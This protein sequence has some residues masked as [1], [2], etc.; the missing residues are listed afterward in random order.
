MLTMIVPMYMSEVS[1][2]AVRGTLVVLQQLSITI[3]ILISYWIEFGTQYIGGT[4]CD[5][6]IPYS[7][8]TTADPT[9]DPYN[10]LGPRGCTGQSEASWRIPLALQ[11]IPA[12]IL[13]IGML[14][15]PESP[16]Y[17]CMR[18]Q[19]EPALRALSTIRQTTPDSPA[20]CRE[21]LT[22]KAEVL[23]EASL[24]RDLYPNKTGVSLYLAQY[25]SLVS[26]SPARKRLAVGCCTM[27]FQQFMGCNAIIYYAPTIFAQLGLS[28]RATSLLATGVYGI[29]NTL[30][31]LPAL[32]LIDRVG[33][34]PLLMA[35]AAGTCVSLVVVA[36]MVGGF[37]GGS[38]AA[39][40]WV[41]IAFIYI[42]DVNFSYSFAP[43][44]WVLPAEI[45]NLGNR[46]KAMSVTTSATW[47]CNFVIGL[48]TPDM[49]ARLGWG[50]Y[51]FFAA[52]CALAGLFTFFFVPE[53]KGMSLEDMDVVFGDVAA[54]EEK[55][56]LFGIAAELGIVEVDGVGGE[57][58][59]KPSV[60][61]V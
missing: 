24:A 11:I 45:F 1:T 30:A 31:T 55:V 58:G 27:F 6:D 14:F 4:E 23:F 15:Y 33:R 43:I 20:L 28:G 54:R 48:V 18:N 10:D 2:P 16:R 22:I 46:A 3:G 49:L 35:G 34:R 60:E 42:Y 29:V 32:F 13:G 37:P 7:G 5:P 51:L 52:F 44:G 21:Y 9:F 53:T 50:T 26:T 41:G 12:L 57:K 47:M 36:A 38:N 40:G 25:A 8:G 61:E 59:E 39:A 19:D 56:R 17:Y